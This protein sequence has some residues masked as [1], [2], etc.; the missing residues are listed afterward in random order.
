MNYDRSS[1][2]KVHAHIFSSMVGQEYSLKWHGDYNGNSR[3][4]WNERSQET[5]DD[6]RSQAK[7]DAPA[8]IGTNGNRTER[9]EDGD[10]LY[11]FKNKTKQHLLYWETRRVFGT[12]C[13]WSMQE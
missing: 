13:S 8:S 4:I 6:M 5:G 1:Q 12:P 7:Q 2:G 9:C 11:L 3:N 10:H